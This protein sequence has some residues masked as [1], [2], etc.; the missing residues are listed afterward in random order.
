VDAGTYAYDLDERRRYDRSTAAHNTVAVDGQDSSEV[1]HIFR[2]G[3]RAYPRDVEAAF[4]AGGLRATAS[5][6]GYD[7]LPGRPR[8][9]RRLDLGADGRLVITDN[10][11]GHRRHRLEGG[12]LLGPG[13][14][15]APSEGGWVVTNGASRVRL[16][17]RGAE[18][19]QRREE[20]RPYHPEYGCEIECI[21]LSWRLEDELPVEIVAVAER[22]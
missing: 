8:H 2:V 19:L 21:R 14:T 18:G 6:T 7:H 17:V 1:W 9:T 22:A 13:W 16:M 4:S 10:I 20:R 12:F 3:R 5:H 15:A 11:A